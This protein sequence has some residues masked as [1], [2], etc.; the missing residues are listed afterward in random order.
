M[1]RLGFWQLQRAEEKELRLIQIAKRNEQHPMGLHD[2]DWLGKEQD[3]KVNF[4]GIL[5]NDRVFL[6]DNRVVKGQV[7]YEVLVPVSTSEG[8][9]L[10]KWGWIAGTGYRDKLPGIT[11]PSSGEEIQSFSGVTWLPGNNI[12]VH[13]TATTE[14]SW[15]M[16]IQEVNITQIEQLLGKPLLPFV[17][18]L[19]LPDD[20]G[21]INNHHPVVMPPEKHIA[22]AIQWFGLA[23]GCVLVFIFASIKK[24]KNDRSED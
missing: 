6:W 17:V 14:S 13:E 22:Y 15:P 21:F 4:T 8:I 12:F 23:L 19:D 2:I 5:L 16:V 24:S 9:V 1:L 20:S 10:T 11:L 7:G 3:V 18:S